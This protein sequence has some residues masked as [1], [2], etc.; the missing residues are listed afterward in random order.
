[1]EL[2]V[3]LVDLLAEISVERQKALGKILKAFYF[4]GHGLFYS[5]PCSG[6]DAG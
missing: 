3:A 1:M 6:A 5:I 4:M 2:F